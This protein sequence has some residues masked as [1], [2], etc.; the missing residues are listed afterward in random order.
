MK[1]KIEH[2]WSRDSYNTCILLQYNTKT[3]NLTYGCVRVQLLSGP[4]HGRSEASHQAHRKWWKSPWWGKEGVVDRQT[5]RQQAG[6]KGGKETKGGRS[7]EKVGEG[8]RKDEGRGRTSGG[9]GEMVEN[10]FYF[11]FLKVPV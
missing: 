1:N 6:K 7:V 9:K 5:D 2:S 11:G 10:H 4:V 3:Y 8:G